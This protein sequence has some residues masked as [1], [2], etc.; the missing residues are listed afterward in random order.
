MSW[1][2]ADRFIRNF[3]D[4]LPLREV[5]SWNPQ[6]SQQAARRTVSTSAWGSELKCSVHT[7]R[8]LPA[9]STS[10]WGSELKYQE[11][12]W[13]T[14]YYLSTSA[15]GSELKYGR[16]SEIEEKRGLPL[17]EVV[18]WNILDNVLSERS[19][20]S[21]SAWGSELKCNLGL[22]I[23]P[24]DRLP[25]REVVSWNLTSAVGFGAL[26]RLPLREVVS[27]NWIR[28]KAFWNHS[29]VYLCVR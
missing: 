28:W 16:S 8:S 24:C 17:R 18:S 23:G 13:C 5:V 26:N 25:L 3:V 10:A 27:W 29:S 15:W 7:S 11:Y 19:K 1:N 22:C 20:M 12:P 14:R 9:W 6:S 21:T 4:C 2:N